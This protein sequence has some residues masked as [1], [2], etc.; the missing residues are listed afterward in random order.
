MYIVNIPEKIKRKCK[1]S[2][3]YKSE[4]RDK[5]VNPIRT[6]CQTKAACL[7]WWTRV[8]NFVQKLLGGKR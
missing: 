7:S 5:P 3:R 6:Y 4:N 8:K 1:G 2:R